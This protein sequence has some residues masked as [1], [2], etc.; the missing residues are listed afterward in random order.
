[1]HV[2]AVVAQAPAEGFDMAIVGGLARSC[3][4]QLYAAVE[5]PRIDGLRG[6]IRAVIDGDGFREVAPGP[7]RTLSACDGPREP[8]NIRRA[9]S[10]IST[11]PRFLHERQPLR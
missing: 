4:I 11:C 6:D 9:S 2:E 3:E 8:A 1:M 5:C 7:S 10:L